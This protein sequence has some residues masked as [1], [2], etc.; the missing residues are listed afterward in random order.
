MHITTCQASLTR[1][2]LRSASGGTRQPCRMVLPCPQHVPSPAAMYI[3]PQEAGP[4]KHTWDTC[5]NL[6]WPY[7]NTHKHLQVTT[8]HVVL[9]RMLASLPS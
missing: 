6:P 1:L 9:Q 2:L 5:N 3:A 4:V 8:M 7:V